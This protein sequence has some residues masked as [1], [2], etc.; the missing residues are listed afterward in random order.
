MK[1]NITKLG[2]NGFGRIGRTIARVNA[3]KDYFKLV[4]INDINPQIDNMTYLLRYDSTYGKFPGEVTCDCENNVLTINGKEAQYFSG[5]NIAEADWKSAGV[6]ILIDSSGPEENVIKAK[7]LIKN[8]I[9]KK[10]IVTHSSDNVDNEIILGINDN[11]LK[12]SDGVISSNICDSSAI[13][14]ILKWIDDEYGLESGSVTTLHPWLSYQNLVDGPSVSQS[15]PGVIWKDYAL[16]RASSS[17][18]IPKETTAVKSIVKILKNLEGK[19][20]SF[21]YRIPTNVVASADIVLR[22]TKAPSEYELKTYLENRIAN[23]DYVR[24]NYESLV[25]LDYEKEEAVAV[26]D[27]QWLKVQNGL[28]KI[29]LWYDNEWGY[30]TNVLKLAKKVTEVNL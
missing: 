28:I 24:G 27:F 20:L 2:I 12:A 30:S 5:K 25:S 17:S 29:V 6:E 9:V 23:S 7:D 10:V 18:L 26:I 11:T 15:Y 14:H 13:A 16:G 22:P 19:L 8:G 1:T 4:A 21:S 3:L